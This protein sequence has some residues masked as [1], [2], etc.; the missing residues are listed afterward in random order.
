MLEKQKKVVN[1]SNAGCAE[2]GKVPRDAASFRGDLFCHPQPTSL[3]KAPVSTILRCK[4]AHPLANL[5]PTTMAHGSMHIHRAY[6]R[7]NQNPAH[8]V[9][10]LASCLFSTTLILPQ[11]QLVRVV[12]GVDG[13][14][15]KHSL[16]EHR[17]SFGQDGNSIRTRV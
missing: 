3:S 1:H 9:L 16:S 13:N 17:P 14:Q 7:S 11:G 4:L 2:S 12:N 6:V 10:L 5:L 8:R 15:L